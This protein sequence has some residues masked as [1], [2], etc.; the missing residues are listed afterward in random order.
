LALAEQ[1]TVSRV[2]GLLPSDTSFF[3]FKRCHEFEDASSL[4]LATFL[5][6]HLWNDLVRRARNPVIN[7][8]TVEFQLSGILH[9]LRA[10]SL[11]SAHIFMPTSS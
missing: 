7:K 2:S 1:P 8:E 4:A 3:L 11:S 10:A 6:I 9:V 5:E